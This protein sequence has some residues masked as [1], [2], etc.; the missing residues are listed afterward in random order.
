MYPSVYLL[1]FM[2]C[3]KHMQGESKQEG[4]KGS[5]IW[6]FTWKSPVPGLA[7]VQYRLFR[8][9]LLPGKIRAVVPT[10]QHWL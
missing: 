1:H 8:L 4:E 9:I 7:G 5:V 2:E 6:I 3:T 10:H